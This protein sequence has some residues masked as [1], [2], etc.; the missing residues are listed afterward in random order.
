MEIKISNCRFKVLDEN[1]KT[2]SFCGLDMGKQVMIPET[3]ETGDKTFTVV[4]IAPETFMNSDIETVQVP[5]SV[6][7]IGKHAFCG[8][9]SLLNVTFENGSGLNDMDD[10]AF[11]ES[12]IQ[13]F[14]CPNSLIRIPF[15]C[16]AFSHL[17]EIDFGEHSQLEAMAG[18]AFAKSQLVSITIPSS[19]EKI[20]SYCFAHCKHLTTVGFAPNS[21]LK[22]LSSYIFHD[23]AI[24]D[25][26]IPKSVEKIEQGAFSVCTSLRQ[27]TFE[28][29][30]NLTCIGVNAFYKCTLLESITIPRCVT[31]IK[32]GAFDHCANVSNVSFEEGSLLEVI[33]S[34]AFSGCCL[35]SMILPSELKTLSIRA[36]QPFGMLEE[37]DMSKCSKLIPD[38]KHTLK[39]G[40]IYIDYNIDFLRRIRREIQLFDFD[41]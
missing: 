21:K 29:D 38:F 36:F 3:I 6:V 15:Y 20:G 25:I 28:Q 33:E 8:C 19:V 31:S 35:S 30:S 10:F 18:D 13:Q 26:K 17:Q 4:Q 24:G 32:L 12:S 37:L 5:K 41:F 34:R 14:V 7:F 16:F 11:A 9:K 22:A 23:S 27:V 40:N 2:I 1:E 39:I